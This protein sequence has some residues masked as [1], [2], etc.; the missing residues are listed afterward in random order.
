MTG[1]RR[2]LAGLVLL[3]LMAG[4]LGLTY[5]MYSGT[6]TSYE[7][8]TLRADRA[9]LV[10][11]EKADVK[12][13][14]VLVGRVTDVD[15]DGDEAVLDLEIRSDKIDVIPENVLA[16][17]RPATVFGAKF[18]DLE[19]PPDPS[20]RHLRDG[21]VLD[22]RGTTVEVNTV[23]ENLV[24]VLSAI[25]PAKL[26]T[27]L[28][29][30]ATALE[31]RGN[32]LGETIEQS[33]RYLAKINADLPQLQQDLKI[34]TDVLNTYADVTPDVLR[35]LDNLRVTSE[36]IVDQREALDAFLISLVGIAGGVT[37]VL[38]ENE[39]ALVNVLDLLRP[40]TGLLAEYSPELTCT[41]Q[42]FDLTR[43]R[44][45]P[46]F[47]IGGI[48]IAPS[49]LP[50]QDPYRNPRDLP[51]VAA[52]NGPSCMGLPLLEGSEL[53]HRFVQTDNGTDI[54]PRNDNVLT[55]GDPPLVEYLFGPLPPLDRGAGG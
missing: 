50:G 35:L 22:S 1:M 36:T 39:R 32:A 2:E 46:L 26:N 16:R 53:P 3:A 40:T 45:E 21:A 52:D 38:S 30:I 42:G 29:N 14:G 37:P 19:M 47:Q 23:F 15:V 11:E 48:R 27:A 18:V 20:P 51:V 31:G 33:D 6:F 17:I 49:F 44:L 5:L 9:G 25:E 28:G 34:G 7:S 55:P 41:I 12:M 43:Q 4:A 54:Y 8:A 24:Q 13:S 10:M